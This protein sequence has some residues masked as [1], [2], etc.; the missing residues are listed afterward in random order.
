MPNIDGN[1]T[2]TSTLGNYDTL[3]VASGATLSVNDTDA[4]KVMG[5]ATTINN[6]GV[7]EA[8]S[9]VP[10]A[11]NNEKFDGIDF[12]HYGTS[13]HYGASVVNNFDDGSISGARHGITGDQPITI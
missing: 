10:R 2:I 7:I 11:S 5:W 1:Q 3:N 6:H 12:G 4:V 8:T 13:S 9:S